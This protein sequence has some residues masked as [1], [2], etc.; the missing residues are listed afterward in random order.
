MI[1]TTR[2]KLKIVKTKCN[3]KCGSYRNYNK[4]EFQN[5]VCTAD[6]NCYN[7]MQ[8]KKRMRKKKKEK[9]RL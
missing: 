2:K 6:W 3:F 8:K 4:E 9:K 7:R 1:L 5:K